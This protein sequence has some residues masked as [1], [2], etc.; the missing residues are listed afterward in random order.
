M[1]EVLTGHLGSGSWKI[2]EQE[3][4]QYLSHR[5]AFSPKSE[6]RIGADEIL[7]VQVQSIQSDRKQVEITLTDGRNAQALVRDDDLSKL[8]HLVSLQTSAPEFADSQKV[9][10]K[11]LIVFLIAGFIFELAK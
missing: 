2:K 3:G 11:W 8:I 1:I 6:Y 5:L 7:D 10:V 4:V 9:W